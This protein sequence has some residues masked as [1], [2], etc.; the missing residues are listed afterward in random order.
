MHAI[1][2][3]HQP[4]FKSQQEQFCCC[5]LEGEECIQADYG[6]REDS[7]DEYCAAT[8]DGQVPLKCCYRS[9]SVYEALGVGQEQGYGSTDTIQSICPAKTQDIQ[10]A[11][12]SPVVKIEML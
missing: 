6:E 3:L 9:K 1:S 12:A 4:I 5:L 10:A 7:L 11:P 8:S 2:N